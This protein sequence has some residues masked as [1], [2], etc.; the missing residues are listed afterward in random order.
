MFTYYNPSDASIK[1]AGILTIDCLDGTKPYTVNLKYL[2]NTYLSTIVD[3]FLRCNKSL[4]VY[5]NGEMI[6]TTEF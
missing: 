1:K 6:A 2:P 3:Q 5:L 4:N